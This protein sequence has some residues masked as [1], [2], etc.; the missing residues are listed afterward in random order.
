MKYERHR[1]RVALKKV[2]A[3]LKKT[4]PDIFEDES[5]MDE[6]MI[7]RKHQ[8]FIEM[9]KLKIEKRWAK[10]CE[11]AEAD[12]EEKP[13]KPEFE[14]KE[15]ETN[16]ERLEKKFDLLTKRLEQSLMQRTDKVYTS[17]HCSAI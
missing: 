8:D 2:D 6:E 13:E 4:R 16:P 14:E 9:E 17:T 3:R 10:M 11:K 7:D 15:M 1:V 12:E 5:D